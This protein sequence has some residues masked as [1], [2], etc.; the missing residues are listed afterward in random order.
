MEHFISQFGGWIG[1]ISILIVG[2]FAFFG[3]FSKEKNETANELITLLSK[4]SDV[5]DKDIRE[6]KGKIIEMEGKIDTLTRENK[7]LKD[8]L[9]G[10]DE[11]TEQFY[12]D[13]YTAMAIIKHN[14]ETSEENSKIL[15]K[16]TTLLETVIKVQK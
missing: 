12:K 4:K 7:T 13:A 1:I 2:G 14:D 10:R 6:L 5:Q 15:A 9:Q 3:K 8:V 11:K 16:I